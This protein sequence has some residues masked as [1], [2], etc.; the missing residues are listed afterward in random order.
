MEKSFWAQKKSFFI[1]IILVSVLVFAGANLIGCGGGGGGGGYAPATS[2]SFYP[3][4][5]NLY[6]QYIIN[7]RE[8]LD[9]NFE[10]FDV[11]MTVSDILVSSYSVDD[12]QAERSYQLSGSLTGEL[13][14]SYYATGL[15]FFT[16]DEN[17]EAVLT[18]ED[19]TMNLSASAVDG[20]GSIIL[21]FS[22]TFDPPVDFF[23]TRNDLDQLPIGYQQNLTTTATVTGTLKMG[24]GGEVIEEPINAE[25]DIDEEWEII[26][27]LDTL[28]IGDVI[29]ENVV[30]IRRQTAM[31]N[32]EGGL[33]A[34]EIDY[35]LAKGIGL[36]QS[37][38]EFNVF[39]EALTAELTSTNLVLT[40]D[41]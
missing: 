24:A 34:E 36:V 17:E 31:P 2:T 19:L 13:V 41:N 20:S 23:I 10:G 28:E 30:Q 39:G 6:W 12:N 5:G 32:M 29:Y 26:N 18:R 37:E 15:Q 40:D 9:L 8:P 16:V 14:G 4:I 22:S 35:W 21:N 11:N 38:G 7:D 1:S 27:K 3:M 33:E 25:E